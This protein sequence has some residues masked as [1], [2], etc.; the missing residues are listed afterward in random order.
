[1]VIER[2]RDTGEASRRGRLRYSGRARRNRRRLKIFR[3]LPKRGRVIVARDAIFVLSQRKDEAALD[4]L[5]GSRAMTVTSACGLARYSG[6]V[7]RMIACGQLI[8]D[9]VSR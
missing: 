6:L 9:R 7:R 3:V 4:E 2:A 1:M 5:L 8:S